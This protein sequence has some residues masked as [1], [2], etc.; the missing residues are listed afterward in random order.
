VRPI[1][2]PRSTLGQSIACPCGYPAAAAARPLPLPIHHFTADHVF[3]LP[4]SLIPDLSVG[5]G[6]FAKNYK[7]L[8]KSGFTPETKIWRLT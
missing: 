2:A 5:F 1:S 7:V 3:C 8:D 4:L 6:R